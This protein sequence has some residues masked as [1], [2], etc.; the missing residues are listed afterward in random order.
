MIMDKQ[1]HMVVDRDFRIAEIDNRMYGSFIEHLGRAVYNGIYQPSHPTADEDGFRKD[2]IDLVKELGVPIVRYPGGNFVSNFYW[3]DSVGPKENRKSRLD[4]AWRTLETNQFGIDEFQKWTKKTNSE[5]MM[6]V[7]L[8]TQGTAEALSLLEYCNLDTPTYYA[9]MRRKNGY[10]KPF[11]IKT[12]CMGNEMDGP[13]QMGHKPAHEYG[14]LAAETAKA[15]KVMDDSLEFV[16]C[17]S[18]GPLMPTF[19]EWERMTMEEAYDYIDYVSLH[20]YYGNQE[21]DTADFLAN[22]LDLENFIHTVCCTID[23]VKAEKRSKKQVNLS[24]DEWNVWYH[25]TEKDNEKMAREPWDQHPHLLEDH[26]N[27]EDA[28]LVGLMLITFLKHAD[29]VR[30]ACLAQ[31]VNVIAP[32]MTEDDGPAWRQT[33]FFPFYQ[34]S[35]YGRGVALMCPLASEKHD[36]K[37]YCDVSDIDATAVMNEEKQEITI[38]A[39]N[40]SLTDTTEF[41]ADLRSF[42]KLTVNEHTEMTG[43]AVDAVNGPGSETVRPQ[44]TNAHSLD[45]GMFRAALKPL[46][47]NVIN[48]HYGV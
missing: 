47:W 5:V 41:T 48:F 3:Q 21:G 44:S 27:F 37:T 8:G 2:V 39:V 40:R 1:A 29:R 10:E 18:S 32:I 6:A 20:R 38:F 35:K 7:N 43:Y 9:D 23:Y 14:L 45:N 11:G 26:Y 42:G 36:T 30:I 16:L 22:T 4:L 24:F 12:W 34:T 19:P 31:L 15:M 28:L 13:W 46:S 17:G 33:I 25:S